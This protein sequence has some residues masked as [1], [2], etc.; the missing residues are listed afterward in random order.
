M[1]TFPQYAFS[2][3]ESAV[4]RPALQVLA[5]IRLKTD[6]CEDIKRVFQAY[7]LAS[8]YAHGYEEFS[9]IESWYH[10]N[11]TAQHTTHTARAVS[12]RQGSVGSA[13]H[14]GWLCDG[15][16]G[17]IILDCRPHYAGVLSHNKFH[18]ALFDT[19]RCTLPGDATIA[20]NTPGRVET[21]LMLL[22]SR[23]AT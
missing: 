3:F 10:I 9:A 15:W 7:I 6:M 12:G 19:I 21:F 1:R 23:P 14:V 4:S 2:V 5:N 13:I 18:R 20:N 16:N 17:N 22:A 8:A 11:C